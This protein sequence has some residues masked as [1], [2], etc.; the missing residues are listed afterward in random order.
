MAG[1][2]INVTGDAIAQLQLLGE[3]ARN[4]ASAL[5]EIG[6]FL[7]TDVTQRFRREQAPDGT[8]WIK[9]AA[10]KKRGGLTLTKSRDLAKSFTY[11]IEHQG[12]E[13][14]S[15]EEYAAI[16]HFGGETGRNHSTVLPARPLIGIAQSQEQEIFDIISDWLI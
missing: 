14:G 12:M 7:R 16:H 13:F 9:S 3:H 5:H 11:N 15:G 10:A 6:A 8:R 2:F 1:V 4:P